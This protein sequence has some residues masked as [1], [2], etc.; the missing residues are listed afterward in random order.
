M[1]LQD[2]GHNTA[3]DPFRRIMDRVA[4]QMSI[5]RRRLDVAVAEELPEHRQ[6]A[7]ARDA[8]KWRRSFITARQA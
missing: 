5:A 6:C 3:C 1:A 4:Y 7:S 8:K 2:V